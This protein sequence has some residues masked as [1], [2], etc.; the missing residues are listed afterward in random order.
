MGTQSQRLTLAFVAT[1]VSVCVV[2]VL[3]ANGADAACSMSAHCRGAVLYPATGGLQGAGAT[4]DPACLTS[5][6]QNFTTDEIWIANSNQTAWAEIG[7][8]SNYFF[9]EL[10][11]GRQIF[12]WGQRADGSHVADTLLVNPTLTSRDFKIWRAAT[13]YISVQF[14]ST[15]T[16]SWFDFYMARA[17]SGSEATDTSSTSW[18]SFSGLKKFYNTWTPTWPSSFPFATSPMEMD[19]TT[20]GS[21][22]WGGIRC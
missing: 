10:S 3:G 15:A 11:Y 5:S 18:S 14:D 12:W 9:A 21:A 13:G 4:I 1:L 2:F 17:D 8:M 7:Y 22:A 16:G 20:A 6:F 19:W